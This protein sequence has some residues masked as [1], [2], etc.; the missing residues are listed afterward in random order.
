LGKQAK[1]EY[2]S[3]HNKLMKLPDETKVFPGHDYGLAPQSTIGN[4][5]LTNPFLLRPDFE[6]FVDLKKNWAEFKA[7]HGIK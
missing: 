5:K 3:L 1:I 6:S 7:I 2:D 4:E